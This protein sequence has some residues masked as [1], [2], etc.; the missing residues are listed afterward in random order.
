M[1]FTYHDSV[2]SAHELSIG[3]DMDIAIIARAVVNGDDNKWLNT[4]THFSTYQLASEVQGSE[5]IARISAS[6]DP[7]AIQAAFQQ[8]R[9][10]PR[11]F[12]QKWAA[13][14]T[15]VEQA[16]KNQLASPTS[17]DSSTSTR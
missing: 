7:A 9:K 15:A 2:I 1:S 12:Q 14:L 17:T 13:E 5:P 8:W 3:D 10:L 6:S 4:H 16:A 11:V